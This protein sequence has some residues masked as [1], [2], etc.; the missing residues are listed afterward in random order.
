MNKMLAIAVGK[1]I[2]KVR[3]SKKLSQDRLAILAKID[4]SYI[5]RIERGEV[6]IT[7][8]ILYKLSETLG[9]DPKELLP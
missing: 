8:E 5:G 2:L 6:N 3:K 1:R 9:C 7:L 4:R